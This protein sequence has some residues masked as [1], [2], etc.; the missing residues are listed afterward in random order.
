M[1]RDGCRRRGLGSG[2][3]RG[4]RGVERGLK[5][6]VAVMAQW[7]GIFTVANEE[8]SGGGGVVVRHDGIENRVVEVKPRRRR[9]NRKIQRADNQNFIISKKNFSQPSFPFSLVHSVGPNILFCDTFSSFTS[10]NRS[11]PTFSQ[12]HLIQLVTV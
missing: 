1:G 10:F 7:E 5:E 11:P 4:L 9:T 2:C 6:R 3:R 12:G 8:H